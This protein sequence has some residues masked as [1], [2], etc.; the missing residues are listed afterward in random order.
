MIGD[1]P[2]LND[3]FDD[4]NDK[5]D[6]AEKTEFVHKNYSISIYI[7]KDTDKWL[8]SEFIDIAVGSI[9][10]HVLLPI[11]IELNSEELRRIRIKFVKKGKDTEEV[12]KEAPVLVRWQENDNLSG[13]LKLGLHFHG[14]TKSDPELQKILKQLK[15]ERD[16]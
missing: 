7:S 10:L 14:D 3:F 9:G 2:D 4:E 1:L 5:S 11:Q 6:G 8:L 12:L 16:R 15:S 13:N